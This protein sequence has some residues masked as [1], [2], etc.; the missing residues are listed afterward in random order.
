MTEAELKQLLARN[1]AI[2]V[3]EN[4]VVRKIHATQPEPGTPDA[5]DAGSPRKEQ[6]QSRPLVRFTFCRTRLVDVDCV[7]GLGKDLLD[8]LADAGLISGDREDQII[9]EASQ[10]KVGHKRDEGIIIEIVYA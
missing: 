2:S 7:A 6:G 3:D 1:P 5:P 10:K 4:S 9:Y 8:G